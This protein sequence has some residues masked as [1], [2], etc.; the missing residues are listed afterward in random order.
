MNQLKV[1]RVMRLAVVVTALAVTGCT[2]NPVE[3][4]QPP[5]LRGDLTLAY[6]ADM[7]L[8]ET[9]HFRQGPN[10]TF[11]VN[12]TVVHDTSGEVTDSHFSCDEWFMRPHPHNPD[13]RMRTELSGL[14]II[15]APIWMSP[16]DMESHGDWRQV[17]EVTWGGRPLREMRNRRAE[18]IDQRV[19]AYY[20]PKTGL[21]EGGEAD[22][23]RG[24]LVLRRLP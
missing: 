2:T 19:V 7:G 10:G 9:F 13:R 20:D 23:T 12:A 5:P 16:S 18:D 11:S 21:L 6:A 8:R 15:D 22:L 1:R 17:G 3:L 14:M 4:D 24:R